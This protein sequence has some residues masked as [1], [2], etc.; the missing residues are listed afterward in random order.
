MTPIFARV[1]GTNDPACA[2]TQ[3]SAVCLRYVDL[4][5]MLGP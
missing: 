4:P 3:M 5:P 1:A 2:M